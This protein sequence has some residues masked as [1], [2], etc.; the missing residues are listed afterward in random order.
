MTTSHAT[1]NSLWTWS[2]AVSQFCGSH[3]PICVLCALRHQNMRGPYLA[4]KRGQLGFRGREQK[5]AAEIDRGL[6]DNLKDFKSFW[7]T[8]IVLEDGELSERVLSHR[9]QGEI[10]ARNGHK[11]LFGYRLF[12]LSTFSADRKW[13]LSAGRA[14]LFG[15]PGGPIRPAGF[16]TAFPYHYAIKQCQNI[17][18][19]R[20]PND[21]W[22]YCVI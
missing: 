17:K 15:R 22:Y 16:L 7:R 1:I 5:C 20:I 9:S 21:Y 10:T 6:D 19:K 14:S 3:N 13:V 12:R 2:S 11:S 4:P 8:G 18:K